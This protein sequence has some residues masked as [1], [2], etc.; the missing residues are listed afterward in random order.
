MWLPSTSINFRAPLV[1]LLALVSGTLAGTAVAASLEQLVMP[2]PV[3]EGH[4][5]FE[6][7][8][9]KCHASFE[10]GAQDSLC[11]DCHED[12][13]G[14]VSNKRGFHG[15]ELAARPQLC[16]NCHAEHNGRA[17]DVIRMN[18][19]LFDHALTDFPLHGKHVGLACAGCHA[20][21]VKFRDAPGRCFD[22]HEDDQPHMGRLGEDCD[23][24]H[25]EDAW[26]TVTFDHDSTDFALTGKHKET[27]CAQCHV[28]EVYE[29]LATTCVSCHA[30][31]DAHR[32]TRGTECGDCHDTASW[33]AEAFDHMKKTGFAL[34]GAHSDLL[35]AACHL[36]DMARPEPPKTCVG[37]HSF[38]DKHGG[39]NGTE[40]DRC[41]TEKTWTAARFDHFA[42]TEFELKGAHAELACQACH[43]GRL[44]DP[45]ETTCDACHAD[46]DPHDGTQARCARC[47]NETT[48]HDVRFN[49]DFT[50][51]PLIGHHGAVACESC[52]LSNVFSDTSGGCVDCHAD[53]DYH[54]GVFGTD[55]G[56]CHNP[57]GWNRWAFDHDTQTQFALTGAHAGLECDACHTPDSGDPGQLPTV[58]KACH[59]KDDIHQGRFGSDCG[60]C[61]TTESFADAVRF[62]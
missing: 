11:L 27:L 54:K 22:C 41:H 4:A 32:G 14:D 57:N 3:I 10:R 36:E 8:C 49:H 35:C 56:Q 40:C 37:C 24:C 58:C 42:E 13:A 12:V 47:H 44:Q 28:G 23:S 18:V 17:A 16:Q 30:R 38:D 53:D 45:L 29:N 9:S 25:V 5:E 33:K 31:D 21:D 61:H 34:R 51:F 43:I 6:T 50:K 20:A 52:H 48:W 2:G 39:R 62:P 59:R 46:D 55:C 26:R 1:V 19:E 7:E 60:R 15:Q